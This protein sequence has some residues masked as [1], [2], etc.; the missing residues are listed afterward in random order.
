MRRTAKETLQDLE[1]RVAFLEREA[2]LREMWDKMTGNPG[3]SATPMEKLKARV[4]NLEGLDFSDQ[5]L[6]EMNLEGLNLKGADLRGAKIIGRN[7]RGTNLEGADLRNANLQG[8]N[9]T[10]ANLKSAK[11]DGANLYLA[12]LN[13]SWTN[14]PLDNASFKGANL[15]AVN[16]VNGDLT[17]ADFRG[18]FALTKYQVESARNYHK[19]KGLPKDLEYLIKNR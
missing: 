13:D 2:V 8:T 17:G 16:M 15:R 14:K 12:T 5:D 9:L 11:L 6:R 18:A 3:S 1:L 7:L 4:K 19:V 10:G